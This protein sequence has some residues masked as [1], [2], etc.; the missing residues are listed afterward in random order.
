MGISKSTFAMLNELQK[1]NLRMIY[2]C[3]PS[4]PIPALWAQA[5]MMDMQQHVWLE[6]VC[7]H[8][9]EGGGGGVSGEG[10]IGGA[11]G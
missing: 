11:D 6:M 7:L 1:S 4:T 9:R 10:G 3:P 8:T 5:G 2:T